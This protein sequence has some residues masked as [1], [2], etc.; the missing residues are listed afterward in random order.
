MPNVISDNPKAKS[1]IEGLCGALKDAGSFIN[2][3]VQIRLE[4]NQISVFTTEDVR[5]EHLFRIP[6]DL[7]IP[8]EYFDLDIENGALVI[9][10]CDER[11]DQTRQHILEIMVALFNEIQKLQSHIETCP[12][13]KMKDHPDITDMLLAAREGPEVDLLKK[14]LNDPEFFDELAV[15]TFLKSRIA[16]FSLHTSK[17]KPQEILMPVVEFLNHHPQGAHYN[18]L[19]H[20]KQSFLDIQIATPIDG[21]AECFACYDRLDALDS[22]LHYGFVETDAPYIKSIP[23]SIDVEG[24]GHID[25]RSFSAHTEPQDIPEELKDLG[26]YFPRILVD[27]DKKYAQVSHLYI[28]QKKAP[29]SLRR[30]LKFLVELLN[31]NISETDCRFAICKIEESLLQKNENYYNTLK[32]KVESAFKNTSM[33]GAFSL[34]HTIQTKKILNYRN[35]FKH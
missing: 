6:H 35:F 27:H 30:V 15:F 23:M 11:L 21:S 5:S 18:N 26:F 13:L 8:C 16:G 33:S 19:Y 2:P 24:I 3:H 32:S 29:F 7:L 25:I 22:F 34:I 12:W 9:A 10:H 31:P 28:P 14:T 1:L 17:N 4:N 20:E